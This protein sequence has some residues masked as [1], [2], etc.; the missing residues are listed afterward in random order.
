[1]DK[2]KA[3]ATKSWRTTLGAFLS[4]LAVLNTV[5]AAP[6]LDDDKLTEPDWSLA[7]A[8]ALGFVALW[9]ARDNGVSSE[10]ALS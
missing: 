5:V 3:A 4:M 9:N 8:A 1:M 2:L 7:L 6:L 10:E